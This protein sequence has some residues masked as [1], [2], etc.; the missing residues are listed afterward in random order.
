MGING[1]HLWVYRGFHEVEHSPVMA[2]LTRRSHSATPSPS[3]AGGHR[4]T[5]FSEGATPDTWRSDDWSLRIQREFDHFKEA[6]FQSG[7]I[8][9]IAA[10]Q[11]SRDAF[12]KDRQLGN[13]AIAAYD[14]MILD[15][16]DEAWLTFFINF[17]GVEVKDVGDRKRTTSG[18]GTRS[19]KQVLLKVWP[20]N[21]R[22]TLTKT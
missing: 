12:V 17:A 5:A 13:Y 2:R 9:S 20:Y 10:P 3:G 8:F 6:L 14:N 22:V 4:I 18:G 1:S 19:Y 15:K 7:G 16:P 21:V 11:E